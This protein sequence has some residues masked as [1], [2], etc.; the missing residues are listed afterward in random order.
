MT[1]TRVTSTSDLE[2]L[3]DA[4]HDRWFDVDAVSLDAAKRELTIPYW[5]AD[6]SRVPKSRDTGLLLD[7]DSQLVIQGVDSY[8]VQ[9]SEQIG[10]YGFNEIHFNGRQIT[11]TGEPYLTLTVPVDGLDIR[12]EAVGTDNPQSGTD[13][14]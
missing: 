2:E 8:T 10:C 5:K 1:V 4:V 3:V 6:L 11:I 7:F 9:D 13:D 12:N 14:R